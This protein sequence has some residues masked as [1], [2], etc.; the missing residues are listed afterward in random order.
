[1][2]YMLYGNHDITKKEF[3]KSKSHIALPGLPELCFYEG[4]ILKAERFPLELR[5]THGHQADL[6]NS[7]YWRLA[8]FLVRYLWAPLEYFGVLD[9]TSSARNNT[10][11]EKLEKKYLSYARDSGVL[12]LTGH[13][14]R[15]MLGSEPSPYF[16]CGSCV[17]P[18]GITCIELCGFCA[19]LI[20]WHASSEKS[21]HFGNIYGQCPPTF[22][23]YITRDILGETDLSLP[24]QSTSAPSHL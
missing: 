24:P 14:H 9:P 3:R 4:L 17:H 10:K 23:L 8:R 16:N 1:R 5:V 6:L 13:T 15:P 19:S 20:K 12:L 22:P 11:K 2:L 7:V 21:G 18:K